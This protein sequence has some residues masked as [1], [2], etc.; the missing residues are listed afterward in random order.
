MKMIEAEDK[1]KGT[2]YRFDNYKNKAAIRGLRWCLPI[3]H[4][5]YFKRRRDNG[6]VAATDGIQKG[7]NGLQ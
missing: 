7:H 4:Q 3:S 1:G 6:I 5:Y 2:H